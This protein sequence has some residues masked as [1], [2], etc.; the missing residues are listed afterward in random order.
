MS[1]SELSEL[2]GL[3]AAAFREELDAL[4]ELPYPLLMGTDKWACAFALIKAAPRLIA[5]AREQQQQQMGDLTERKDASGLQ[6]HSAL[7]QET[8]T[9]WRRVDNYPDRSCA[10]LFNTAFYA[11]DKQGRMWAHPPLPALPEQGSTGQEGG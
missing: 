5:Q 7:S 8:S 9:A 1:E 2:E 6:V 10:A 4:H 3:H 11:M